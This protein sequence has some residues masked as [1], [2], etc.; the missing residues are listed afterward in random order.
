MGTVEDHQNGAIIAVAAT[1]MTIAFITVALRCYVRLRLVKAFGWDDTSMVVAMACYILFSA[2]MIGAGLHGNGR[3]WYNV[4]AEERVIAMKYWWLCEIAFCFSSIFCKISICIF[5]MRIC[6]KKTHMWTLYSVMALTVLA[7]LVFMF[8]MLLQCKPLSYFWTRM[9]FHPVVNKEGEGFCINME[10]IV[11]MTYVYSVFAAVCDFTVGIL[12]I[13]VVHQLQMKRQTKI[14]VIGILSMA[15]IA[16]SAVIVRIPFVSTFLD[17][18]DFLFSTVQIAYWSNL[19]IG[20]GITAGSLATLRPLLRHWFGSRADPSYSAGF[21][22]QSYGRRTGGGLSG[23]HGAALPLG[24]ISQAEGGDLRPDKVS[25]MVTNIESQRD[26]KKSWPRPSS[27]SSSEEGLNV[28]HPPL[29]G[30]MEVGVHQTFEV[31]RT[32]AEND[33]NEGYHHHRFERENV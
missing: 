20:L 18:N 27:P 22:K 10:I 6:I 32:A 21:P 17:L 25:V 13:F 14:A 30:R 26:S 28:H 15:C 2:S 9:A 5:L 33:V 29:P 8:L 24:S 31:I 1:F 19:E 7:G 23:A 4:P 12:P 16:S 3:H 11:A